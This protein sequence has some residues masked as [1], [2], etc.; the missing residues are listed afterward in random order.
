MSM[1]GAEALTST[2]L[3]TIASVPRVSAFS[4]WVICSG[5][6]EKPCAATTETSTP[7]FSA[8]SCAPETSAL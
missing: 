3:S 6:V 1:I 7:A 4:A 2:G 5:A 8:A